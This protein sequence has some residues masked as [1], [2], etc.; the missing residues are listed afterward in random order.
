MAA[1]RV[2]LWLK[3]AWTVWL[4]A[5]APIYWSHYGLQNFLFFCD[6]GNILIGIGLWLES[7][8]IFSWQACGLLVFQTLYTIDLAGALIGGHHVIGGTEY[9]FNPDLPLFMRLLSLFHVVTPPLLVWAIWR[10][11]YVLDCGADQLFL[12]SGIRCELGAGIVFSGSACGAGSCVST[13]VSGIGA[14]G[15][16]FSY[17]SA[18]GLAD[19]AVEAARRGWCPR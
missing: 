18:T 14:A 15:Y 16:L 6:I 4:I 7:P 1:M 10:H 19:A 9:M 2:P 12:A 8:L 17:A 13:G 5:W 3:I 11:G